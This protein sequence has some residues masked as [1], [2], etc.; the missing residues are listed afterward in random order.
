MEYIK[1]IIVDTIQLKRGIS[2]R[3]A[4]VN[5]IL[6]LG[7]PGFETD[8]NQLKIGDGITEWNNL[9]YLTGGGGGG[10]G[11]LNLVEDTTPQ[12]GGNLDLNGNVITGLEIGSDIQAY[13]SILDNTTASFTTAIN[14]AIN[15][16]TAKISYPGPQ[17]AIEVPFTP[18]GSILSTDVQTAIE[19]VRD[20][21][22]SATLQNLSLTGNTINI[23]GG[24]GVDLTPILGSG[25]TPAL[26]PNQ[27]NVNPE[28]YNYGGASYMAP[29]ND[30]NTNIPP[31]WVPDAG[32]TVTVGINDE[33]IDV[34]GNYV[35]EITGSGFYRLFVPLNGS[36]RDLNVNVRARAVSGSYRI[37]ELAGDPTQAFLTSP[38]T[39]TEWEILEIPMRWDPANY[40]TGLVLA[41]NPESAGSI[42]QIQ[43]S[44]K[45]TI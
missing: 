42:V 13:S 36:A 8:T 31:P 32:L 17:N 40:A 9:S 43:M 12:L 38:Q 35:L 44:V 26:Y 23:T 6:L 19:E 7:E 4:S 14:N 39:N 41:V 21:A 1:N 16:N 22:V 25:A 24:T 27:T 29:Y 15:A 33:N 30:I 10:S 45:E 18:N 3:W 5:P 11:L 34:F 2:S 37:R 20:E 28:L